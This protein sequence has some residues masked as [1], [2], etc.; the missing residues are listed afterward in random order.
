M[1][2]HELPKALSEA[3]KA[4]KKFGK[5]GAKREIHKKFIWGMPH[6]L[7]WM[8]F[9]LSFTHMRSYLSIFFY[10]QI[11]NIWLCI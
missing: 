4:T 3:R 8:L 1:S 10:P 6:E 5:V 7:P 9:E 2:V 11:V